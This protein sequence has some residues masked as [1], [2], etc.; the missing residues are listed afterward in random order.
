M[1]DLRCKDLETSVADCIYIKRKTNEMKKRVFP[2]WLF[3][4]RWLSS[5][6]SEEIWSDCEWINKKI[7]VDSYFSI[8]ATSLPLTSPLNNSSTTRWLDFCLSHVSLLSL[9]SL[10]PSLTLSLS[11]PLLS[12]L[13]CC[14]RGIS[15]ISSTLWRLAGS[16]SPWVTKRPR[17]SFRQI[18][19]PCR[20]S[21]TTSTACWAGGWTSPKLSSR[22]SVAPCQ[23]LVTQF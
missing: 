22:Y 7:D 4:S 16:S 15:A 13:S 3:L 2:F 19:E 1:A 18:W 6:G 23:V 21:G 10:K 8:K 5:K 14:S 11:L 9:P 17:L 12:T 20:R